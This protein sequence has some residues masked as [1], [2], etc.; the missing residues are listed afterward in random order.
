MESTVEPD[1][2]TDDALPDGVELQP[3]ERFKYGVIWSPLADSLGRSISAPR[4]DW[5][6]ERECLAAPDNAKP[7]GW[8]GKAH[9]MREF[10]SAIWGHPNDLFCIQWNPNAIEILD[11][12]CENKITAVAGHA[13]SGKSYIM[14]AI[15]C[16]EFLIN[17]SDTKVLVTSYTKAASLG[18]IWG[19][20]C[21]CWQ[22]AVSFFGGN[23]PGR[24]LQG[25]HVIRYEVGRVK[26]TKA[27]IELLAGESSEAKD[28]SEKIQGVKSGTLIVLGDEYATLPFSIH[29]T[30]LSNLRANENS[31]LLAALNP[32]SF[33]DPGGVLCRPVGG[34]HK[35]NVE[36]F[37][38]PTALGGYCIH[39]DGE[40]SP[41]VLDPRRP[42]H[43]ILDA[44]MLEDMR[45]VNPKGTKKDDQ[46]VRGWWSSSGAKQAIYDVADIEKFG[47][48]AKERRWIGPTTFVAGLDIG[49]A[50][51]GDKTVLTFGR[52]GMAKN[53]AGDVHVVCQREE[54]LVL[55]ENM[56]LDD[57]LSEQIVSR[58]KYEM[59]EGV[60]GPGTSFEGQKRNVPTA[61]LAVDTTG[62]GTHFAALLARDIGHGFLMIGFGEKASDRQ[63]AK[64]DKRKGHEAFANKVS[65]LWGVG[66]QLVRTG[67]LRNMDPDLV[68]ELTVRTYK[69]DANKRMIIESKEDMK[70]RTN[71][72]SPDRADSYVLMVE[73]ARV[74]GGL[75]SS[76]KAAPPNMPPVDRAKLN[77]QMA[78]VFGATES[79]NF[80]EG[81]WGDG[82]LNRLQR[83][84]GRQFAA[85]FRPWRVTVEWASV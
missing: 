38:W 76:E 59:Q 32:D 75:S 23:V 67:Q 69:D 10:I 4:P 30:V 79:V 84:L 74:R 29:N 17:P 43:R 37:G 46:Y 12:Y 22:V 73:A 50:H 18:K 45:A 16:A 82:W 48:D 57:S 62:G 81:G 33:T 3:F 49:N 26:N 56:S 2:S 68:F 6:I 14:A 11:R 20:V 53:D 27:G 28:S 64:N 21:N 77:E 61:N 13:S 24:L 51:G 25:K 35:V 44:K 80:G 9:H 1:V 19:D 66:V 71:G 34:W 52:V 78:E 15:G 36:F 40:K 54:T 85:A 8:R 47:A 83:F 7:K 70:Q 5:M 60:W 42:W 31:R 63:V 72:Q 39:F 55:N 41:N 65:E 58:V